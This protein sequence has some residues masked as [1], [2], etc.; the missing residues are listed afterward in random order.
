M[1]KQIIITSQQLQYLNTLARKDGKVLIK[2]LPDSSVFKAKIGSWEKYWECASSKEWNTYNSDGDANVGCHV[3]DIQT[4]EIFICPKSRNENTRIVNHEDEFIFI[5]DKDMLVPFNIEDSN[6]N[7]L[8]KSPEE[9]L[10]QAL[11]KISF[12]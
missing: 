7:G 1:G 6:Y 4:R 5:A 10:K 3:V 11:S 9:H 12:L 2:H 8:C